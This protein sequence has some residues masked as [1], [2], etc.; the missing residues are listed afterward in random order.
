MKIICIENNYSGFG[1]EKPTEPVFFMKPD[2]AMLRNNQP[3]FFP[4]HTHD[5]QAKVEL[6]LHICRLGR[7]INRR[8]AHRYYDAATVG[9]DFTASDTLQ[10]C[11]EL[12]LPWD[13]AKTFDHSAP[14]G[15]FIPKD[16]LGNIS[17]IDFSLEINGSI[18]QSGS[19]SNMIFS[20]DELIEH[21]SKYTTY[22]TGDFLFTGSPANGVQVRIGDRL[23]A[24]LN[25]M[26]MIDFHVK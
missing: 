10:R 19:S 18:V 20:F 14:I 9:I 7:H 4:N 8:F 23:K 24:Y 17:S 22:R 11:K 3:F 16:E 21:T 13:M 25:G 12:G 1:G 2:T 15:D 5:I 26:L 6:V